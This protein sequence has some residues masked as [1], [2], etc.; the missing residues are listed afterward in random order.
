MNKLTDENFNLK[1]LEESNLYK[2][3]YLLGF[4]SN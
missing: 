1:I 4:N 2:I 3:S